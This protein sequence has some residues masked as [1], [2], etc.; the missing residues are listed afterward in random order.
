MS[1]T[2]TNEKWLLTSVALRDAY[3]DFILSRQAMNCT[4]STLAFYRYTDGMHLQNLGGW[5]NLDMVDHY[6]QMDDIDLLE[7]PKAPSPVDNL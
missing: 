4:P 1:R 6:A 7:A 3:T 5:E 2:K